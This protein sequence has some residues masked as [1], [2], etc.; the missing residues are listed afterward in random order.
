MISCTQ[1]PPTGGFGFS[2]ASAGGPIVVTVNVDDEVPIDTVPL[3]APNDTVEVDDMVITRVGFNF[4]F[5]TVD[6]GE[7]TGLEPYL[8]QSSHLVAIRQGDLAY[9]HLH[10]SGDMAGM[11]MFGGGITDPGTYRM[12]LQFGR[13]GEVITV[14]FTVVIGEG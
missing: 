10:P 14:P 13:N 9:A 1:A 2:V 8:G 7:V 12:F 6:G 5:E 11:F 4:T 3:P